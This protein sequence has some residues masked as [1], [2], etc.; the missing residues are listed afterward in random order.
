MQTQNT[1]GEQA[2][3]V[4]AY[5]WSNRNL[6]PSGRWGVFLYC[7][8]AQFDTGNRV[9]YGRGEWN[10]EAQAKASQEAWESR[11]A[12]YRQEWPYTFMTP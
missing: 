3:P 7:P 4:D 12:Q 2:M 6:L 5:V 8:G 11:W 1:T 10:T 9:Y